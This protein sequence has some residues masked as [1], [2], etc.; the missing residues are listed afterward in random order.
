MPNGGLISLVGGSAGAGNAIGAGGLAEGIGLTN[1]TLTSG[2]GVITLRGTGQAGTASAMGVSIVVN[3]V[4]NAGAGSI[5]I[6]GQGGSGAGSNGSRGVFIRS[7]ALGGTQLT[8]TGGNITISGTGGSGGGGGAA[9]IGVQLGQGGS[10]SGI[11]VTTT[12]AGTINV[13]GVGGNDTGGTN[14]GVGVAD[15]STLTSANG[16]ITISGTGAGTGANNFGVQVLSAGTTI[17]STGAAAAI[18]LIGQGANGAQGVALGISSTIGGAS[19]LGNILMRSLG[20]TGVDLSDGV[21]RTTGTGN[22]TL[23]LVGGGGVAQAAGGSL[24]ASGLRVLNDT[25]GTLNLTGT[26]NNVTTIAGSLVTG[27]V[28]NFRDTNGF[29][30]GSVTS[31]VDGVAANTTTNGLTVGVAATA[32]DTVNLTANGPITQTAAGKLT[33]GTLTVSNNSAGG[34]DLSTAARS[35]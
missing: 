5:S 28:L 6:T 35:R 22:V 4:V 3:S 15:N 16:V 26:A 18:N 23:N 33:T 8:T 30:I 2:G 9:F 17:S 14:A 11:A 25:S 34:T 32:A 12:G 27:S 21:V 31:S 29:A 20:G 1:A 7:N 24:L 13:T 19:M 10:T